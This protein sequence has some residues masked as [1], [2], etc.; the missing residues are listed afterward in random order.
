VTVG[1]LDTDNSEKMPRYL[2][3]R[4]IAVNMTKKVRE[5]TQGPDSEINSLREI[6]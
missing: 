1:N 6:Y 2:S 5:E 4:T 3:I